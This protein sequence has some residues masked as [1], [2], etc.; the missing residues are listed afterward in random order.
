MLY[1]YNTE[2]TTKHSA[3]CLDEDLNCRGKSWLSFNMSRVCQ[4]WIAKRLRRW[5]QN[6]KVVSSSPAVG[7]KN[8]SFCKSRF[9]AY[10]LEEAHSKKIN[11]DIHLAIT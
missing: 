11:H 8:F 5:P 6:L 3:A 4:V 1:E 9:R 2:Y 10:Q 7:K